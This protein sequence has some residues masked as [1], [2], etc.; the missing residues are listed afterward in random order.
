MERKWSW[1]CGYGMYFF[2][3][4]IGK[5]LLQKYMSLSGNVHPLQVTLQ[6]REIPESNPTIMVSE[7]GVVY[8]IWVCSLM[9][10]QVDFKISLLAISGL[11]VNRIDIY[12]EVSNLIISITPLYPLHFLTLPSLPTPSL[13]PS[14]SIPLH[15]SPPPHSPPLLFTSAE[16]QTFQGHQVHH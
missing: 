2:L 10:V 4:Q 14:L 16:V 15:P 5:I 9:F 6:P 1:G 13:Y 8:K 11:K 7:R 3:F 12:C